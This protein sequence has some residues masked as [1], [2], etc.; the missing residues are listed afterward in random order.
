MKKTIKFVFGRRPQQNF[1]FF[2]IF[3]SSYVGVKNKPPSMLNSG[4]GYEEVLKIWI[5]KTTST[6]KFL[7]LNIYSSYVGVKL[8]TKNKSPSLLN[9]GD[10]Y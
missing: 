4:D 10:G 9:S 2:L 8:H 6:K 1:N 7:N 3:F 5:K